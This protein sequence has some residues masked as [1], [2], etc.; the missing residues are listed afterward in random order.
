M[1]RHLSI[2]PLHDEQES[3]ST[4]GEAQRPP[5]PATARRR[6]L[7][8]LGAA[9]GVVAA[10]ATLRAVLPHPADVVAALRTAA[11][12]WLALAA[13]AEALSMSMFAWQQRRLLGAFGVSMSEPRAEALAYT[14]SALS[15][16]MP[17]GAV[18]SAG[19]AYRQY[20][21]RGASHRVAATVL[22]LSG[23]LSAAGL[24]ILY[25]VWIGAVAVAGPA[26]AHPGVAVPAI[27]ATG[28]AGWAL[29]H[30]RS[31]RGR[32]I[33][34][35]AGR[36][37]RAAWRRSLMWLTG[38]WPRAGRVGTS[39]ADAVH[40]AGTLR[41][42]DWAAALAFA[43]GNWLADLACLIAVGYAFG[44]TLSVVQFA[45][46]YLAVQIV[47]QIPITPGGIGLI[48][49]SLLLAL[50]TA[51]APTAAAAAVVLVYRVLSC[52]LIVPAGLLAWAALQS[53]GRSGG[54]RRLLLKEC[55][56]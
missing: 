32:R 34:V 46:A 36:L 21:S 42:G 52:W 24:A 28:T 37:N 49:A 51:G 56:A 53:T 41:R 38:R 22:A 54:H 26:L 29:A 50:V 8:I 4:V 44:L 33:R 48:E 19:F 18:V 2:P 5:Q 3:G 27:V 47:R 23:V 31:S 43:V 11:V 7:S 13:V 20:Q 1:E 10:V 6:V 25:V 55:D 16:T 30:H 9:V 14:R 45:G 15:I 17:A 39:V 40:V 12:G 35:T